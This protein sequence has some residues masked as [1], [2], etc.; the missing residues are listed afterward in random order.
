MKPF[1]QKLTAVLAASALMGAAALQGQMMH[2]EKRDDMDH[3][4]M[5][6]NM[7]E[8]MQEMRSGMQ[9]MH[10][11]M[12][13]MDQELEQQL[14]RLEEAEGEARIDAIEETVRTLVTQRLEMHE[15]R[16]QMMEG[17]MDHMDG[18]G[19]MSGEYGE[20][21]ERMRRGDKDQEG[22]SQEKHQE[23]H[24]PE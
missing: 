3:G 6:E 1:T 21:P 8:R 4:E 19:M 17:M 9:A 10:Q 5:M 7:R 20:R 18:K 11:R 15:H 16:Q 14:Q 22:V 23:G 13:Q 24:H 2:E 12:R